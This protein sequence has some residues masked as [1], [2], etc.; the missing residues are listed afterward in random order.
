[1]KRLF[2]KAVGLVVLG[3]L[4]SFSPAGTGDMEQDIL[5]ATNKLRRS[6]G[7]N[8]LVMRSDL[9][10][11]ARRHSVDMA[12]GKTAFGH[13]GFDRRFDLAARKIQGMKQFSE[14][15]AYGVRSGD[16]VVALWKKSPGHRR[17]MLGKFKYMGVGIASN[18]K[19]IKY[20]TQVF[21]D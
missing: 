2:F 4:F 13:S 15:V 16:E 3:L 18:R 7:L 21:A 12:S 17:N 9:N 8:E 11:I 10:E 1:M 14:N 6:R 5:S 20:F 19:G